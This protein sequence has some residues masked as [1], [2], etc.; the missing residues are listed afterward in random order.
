MGVVLT[1]SAESFTHLK[2]SYRVLA[3]QKWELE[4]HDHVFPTQWHKLN[5]FDPATQYYA[6]FPSELS[7]M[8]FKLRWL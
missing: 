7:A 3:S 5:E 4:S 6:E 8:L 2:R 1:I